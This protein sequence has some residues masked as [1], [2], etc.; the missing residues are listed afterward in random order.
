[1]KTQVLHVVFRFLVCL[2]L[3][4]SFINDSV[5]VSAAIALPE[6]LHPTAP[7]PDEPTPTEDEAF[8]TTDLPPEALSLPADFAV[9]A[10]ASDNPKLDSTMAGLA[11]AARVSTKEALDLAKSQSLR[12]SG[13][14]VHVQVVVHAPG[15]QNVFEAVTEAGGEVTGVVND[16]TLIQGWLPIDA[17]EVVAAQKD[18]YL[19]RQPAEVV[20]LRI[21]MQSMRPPKASG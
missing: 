6:R 3:L 21:C 11:A 19:I 17:L 13:N 8:E 15:L 7:V 20:L 18:V 5:Q 12:L 4:L 10:R 1:M 2:T 16:D 14:R 9:S